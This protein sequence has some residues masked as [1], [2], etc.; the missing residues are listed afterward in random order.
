MKC[1]C[2]GKEFSSENLQNGWHKGCI[3]NFFGTDKLPVFEVDKEHLEVL[4]KTVCKKVSRCREYR[5]KCH[6]TY[7]RM[8]KS[9]DLRW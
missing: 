1:L 4:Q 7:F 5:K 2:C 3:R 8:R 9:R 6:C